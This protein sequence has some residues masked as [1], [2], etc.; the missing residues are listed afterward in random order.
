[1]KDMVGWMIARRSGRGDEVILDD[2]AGRKA[3][4]ERRRQALQIL[5]DYI[6]HRDETGD[7]LVARDISISFGGLKALSGVNLT[8]PSH[9]FVGLLGPNG[10]G[11]STLFD[12]VNGLKRPDTGAIELFGADV[13]GTQPWDRAE[14]GMSRTFQ[15]NRINP[16]LTVGENLLAGAHKMI[17]TSLAG[18]LLGLGRARAEERRAREAAQAVAYLLDLDAVW[19]ERAGWLN[20]GAQRRIEIGRALLSGPRLLLLDEPAAGLDADEAADLFELIRRLQ[21][22]LGLSILLV[23]HYVKA[24]LENA[25][26]VYVLSQGKVLAAGSPQEIA[27]DP[28]VRAEYL[29]SATYDL[30][31]RVPM[32]EEQIDA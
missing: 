2:G 14:L 29:G 21:D 7:A 3:D 25:D 12:V 20:F 19:D 24:V 9:R 32:T 4:P 11:K 18:E 30:S 28:A 27:T 6:P 26:L 15:S 23:E 22:D 17:R 5:E 10:A 13:T 8:V 31:Q 16:E 1:M